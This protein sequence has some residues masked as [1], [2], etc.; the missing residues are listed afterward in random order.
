MA[1]S[2]IAKFAYQ[3]GDEWVFQRDDMEGK[4]YVLSTRTY[5]EAKEHVKD[6]DGSDVFDVPVGSL[7]VWLSA[8]NWSRV[9]ADLFTEDGDLDQVFLHE[10]G[11]DTQWD[12]STA[13]DVNRARQTKLKADG[14]LW[15]PVTEDNR[16]WIW[17]ARAGDTLVLEQTR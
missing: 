17:F 7:Y 10:P 14:S 12:G 8:D 6:G 9:T 4:R 1:A 5:A 2:C 11:G 13:Y 3:S 15:I 16:D